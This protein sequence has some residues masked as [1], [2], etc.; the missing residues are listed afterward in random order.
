MLTLCIA[1]FMASGLYAVPVNVTGGKDALTVYGFVPDTFA[2]DIVPLNVAES[3]ET[4]TLTRTGVSDYDICKLTCITLSATS[5]RWTVSITCQDSYGVSS[6]PAFTPKNTEKY[7]AGSV[8]DIGYTPY[9]KADGGTKTSFPDGNYS[10]S[11]ETEKGSATFISNT[12]YIGFDIKQWGKD[13]QALEID[14]TTNF[15]IT[16]T[17]A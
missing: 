4:L 10:I 15:V 7:S 9:I 5:H 8:Q 2:V 12:F 16:V 11:V 17:T 13:F 6:H 3:E 14:Y 1:I